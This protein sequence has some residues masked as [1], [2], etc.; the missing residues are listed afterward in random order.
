MTVGMN[1]TLLRLPPSAP[2]FTMLLVL[3]LLA[4]DFSWP[5]ESHARR[6]AAAQ[7]RHERNERNERNERDERTAR[8]ARHEKKRNQTG[9]ASFYGPELRNHL[10]ANG[11]RFDPMELTA[12]HRWL[13]F[14]TRVRVTNLANGRHVV[15]RINDRGPYAKGR[16]LDVSRSAARK[17]GFLR[18]GVAHVR[19]QVLKGRYPLRESLAGG[20]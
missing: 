2:R 16:V 17:L 15:V 6:G 19:L 4:A 20:E 10:T 18:E 11:E 3:S 8:K 12:A 13:P 5:A 1:T 7:E 9:L 14:G